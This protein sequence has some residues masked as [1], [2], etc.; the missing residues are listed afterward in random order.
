MRVLVDGD[1]GYVGAVLV[2]LLRAHGHEVVGLDVGWYDGCDF[3][4]PAADYEQRTGDV[5]DAR[6]EDLEGFDAVVHLAAISNDPIGHL[7]PD[8]TFSVNAGGAVHMAEAAKAAGVPRFLFSSSC[9]LYG[10]AGDAPVDEQSPFHPVTP[11]GESKVR[12][13]QGISPLADDSFSPTY[14]RNATAYGSSRR[15]RADIVVNNLTGT[16]FTRGE[17]RLQSDGSPWRPLVHV[18]DIARAFL[19]ALE[20]PRE[21]VHDQAFNVGRDEDVVQIRTVAEQV[22]DVTGA[23]VTFAP[24]AGADARNYRVDFG[25]IRSLLPAADPRWTVRDGIEELWRDMRQRGLT[26]EDFE[27]TFVRLHRIQ[28]LAAAGRLDLASLRMVVAA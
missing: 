12:A 26:T 1:R 25:K 9:S 27:Q 7:A 16:A 19:A 22:A 15:L 6:P 3:G 4:T 2:P 10:A 5:R 8:A 28:E 23:P 13:E 14:L 20:A 24:G 17:V 21:V 18:Q 11:Y